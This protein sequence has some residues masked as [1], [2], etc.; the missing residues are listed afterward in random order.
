MSVR[1]RKASSRDDKESAGLRISTWK[2]IFG[3]RDGK[4]DQDSRFGS[5]FREHERGGRAFPFNLD[6]IFGYGKEGNGKPVRIGRASS[7]SNG[8]IA[9]TPLEAIGFT[10][11][12]NW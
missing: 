6:C 1:P 2:V 8:W 5:I 9:E 3:W 11:G 7:G 4:R 10:E 12:L